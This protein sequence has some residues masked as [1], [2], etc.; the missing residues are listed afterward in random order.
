MALHRTTSGESSVAWKGFNRITCCSSELP[1]VGVWG[2]RFATLLLY[3][4]SNDLK[5]FID[6][7]RSHMIV[8]DLVWF[9]QEVIKTL[10]SPCGLSCQRRWMWKLL[11]GFNLVTHSLIQLPD[12]WW[13]GKWK[14]N[15]LSGCQ[16]FTITWTTLTSSQEVNSALYNFTLSQQSILLEMDVASCWI[17][18]MCPGMAERP[19]VGGI[20]GP[21]FACI[22]GQQFLNLRKGDRW[23]LFFLLALDA[24]IQLFTQPNTSVTILSANCSYMC[25]ISLKSLLSNWALQ[26]LNARIEASPKS[27]PSQSPRPW[28]WEPTLWPHSGHTQATLRPHSRTLW[29]SAPTSTYVLSLT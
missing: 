7:F 25:D 5:G 23:A 28:L 9:K 1:F 14:S 6:C 27:K 8:L 17:S 20:V 18:S 11:K 2:S 16:E 22:I 26:L 4:N 29:R 13:I 12:C 15:T 21:T 10:G 3:D 19:V 24:I